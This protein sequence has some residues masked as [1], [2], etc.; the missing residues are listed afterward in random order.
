M[1]TQPPRRSL[2]ARASALREVER[3]LPTLYQHLLVL[4][5]PRRR[6]SR[7]S[8]IY[9]M[10]LLYARRLQLALW[11]ILSLS[12]NGRHLLRKSIK[13]LSRKP[14]ANVTRILSASQTIRLSPLISSRIRA[15]RLLIWG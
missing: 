9:P 10:G 15:P 14:L 8:I 4:R 11:S 5:V 13:S 3:A 12:R 2:I 7:S 1:H 6:H